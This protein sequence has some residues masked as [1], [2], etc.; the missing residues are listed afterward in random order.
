MTANITFRT[1]NAH[2]ELTGLL[3][4]RAEGFRLGQWDSTLMTA[5]QL[6]RLGTDDQLRKRLAKLMAQ[7]CFRNT[8]LENQHAETVP[9]S[10]TRDYTDVKVVT[11]HGEIAWS[12]L[13]RLND[14]EMKIL[15]IEVVSKTY[16]FLSMLFASGPKNTRAYPGR[17]TEAGHGAALE[18][19]RDHEPLT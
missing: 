18:R 14:E 1:V 6:K 12:E 15:M 13:S 17:L 9:D 2:H 16:R 3:S 8:E 11:P 4:R 7:Q 10:I 5:K 19:S